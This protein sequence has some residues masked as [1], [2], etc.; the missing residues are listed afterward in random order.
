[1]S[2]FII[3]LQLINIS[4]SKHP[5]YFFI[6]WKKTYF[7]RRKLFFINIFFERCNSNF[8]L[9]VLKPHYHYHKIIPGHVPRC[10][11]NRNN[12]QYIP[13]QATVGHSIICRYLCQAGTCTVVRILPRYTVS[14]DTCCNIKQ[15]NSLRTRN[16]SEFIL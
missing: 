1:M 11:L 7:W 3:T 12:L 5:I 8:S 13:A 16:S 9:I 10:F 6:Q 15:R 14:L 4:P 2:T